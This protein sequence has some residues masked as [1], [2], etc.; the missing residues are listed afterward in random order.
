L[1]ISER[2]EKHLAQSGEI[3]LCPTSYIC[4]NYKHYNVTVNMKFIQISVL[5][6]SWIIFLG[7]VLMSNSSL[8]MTEVQTYNF[9]KR[10]S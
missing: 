10:N 2:T 7:F 6:F 1:K 4:F 8:L 9:L 5:I 3:K